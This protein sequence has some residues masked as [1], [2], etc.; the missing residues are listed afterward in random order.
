MFTDGQNAVSRNIK[1]QGSLFKPL[2]SKFKLVY[3][4]GSD[5]SLIVHMKQSK[6]NTL[7]TAMF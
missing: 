1:M 7:G 6:Q 3:I 5:E 4:P 2:E